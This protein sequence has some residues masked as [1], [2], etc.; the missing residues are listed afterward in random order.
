MDLHISPYIKKTV[1]RRVRAIWFMRRVLPLLVL[2]TV[3]VAFIVRQLAA[4]VFFNQVLQNA[5][6]HTFTRSPVMMADF[7]FRAL[8]NTDLAVQI[9]A[10]G[11]VLIGAL[12]LRDT[13]RTLR[14]FTP[15][16]VKHKLVTSY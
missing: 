10:A 6:A 8:L 16:E 15:L 11:S 9:L 4:Y 7:F 2:E 3:A 13:V 12:L 5:I 14:T 1:M